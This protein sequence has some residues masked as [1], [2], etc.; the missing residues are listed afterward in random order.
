[1]SRRHFA[2]LEKTQENNSA[3]LVSKVNL[4]SKCTNKSDTKVIVTLGKKK[5]LSHTNS[6]G[7]LP[8]PIS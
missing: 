7:Q 4:D 5:L 8:M 6:Y 1:M 3:F 2:P